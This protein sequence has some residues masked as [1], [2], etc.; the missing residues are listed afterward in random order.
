M[1]IIT[2][3]AL[4]NLPAP[5]IIARVRYAGGE[6]ECLQVFGGRFSENDFTFMDFITIDGRSC[7]EWSNN[8]ISLWEGNVSIA[9]D[10]PDS[11]SR[12]GLFR[13][14]CDERFILFESADLLQ[15]RE[16]IDAALNNCGG[17]I[18]P[19]KGSEG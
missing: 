4:L 19:S 16:Y 8:W 5:Q 1:K 13:S 12:D 18:S 15:M 7:D 10:E 17:G 2:R 9:M 6:P 3:S 14:D 11:F